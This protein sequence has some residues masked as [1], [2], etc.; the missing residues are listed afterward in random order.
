[1]ERGRKNV[2]AFMQRIFFS[3]PLHSSP[4]TLERSLYVR[5]RRDQEL[6]DILIVLGNGTDLHGKDLKT[7]TA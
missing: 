2:Q 5:V 1:M 6:S 7:S 3:Y 4:I